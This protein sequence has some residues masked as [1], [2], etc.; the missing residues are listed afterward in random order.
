MGVE[1]IY[2]AL[3]AVS[4]FRNQRVSGEPH[5]ST[6][7]VR[8]NIHSSEAR[9]TCPS[10]NA[11]TASGLLPTFRISKFAAKPAITGSAVFVRLAA[12]QL[13]PTMPSERQIPSC[14][15]FA[16]V[17]TCRLNKGNL[18]TFSKTTALASKTQYSCTAE[19]LHAILQR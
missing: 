9:Q 8:L 11:E 4:A 7:S 6:T 1:P 14:A 17:K 2:T 3:Q 12:I 13:A 18:G 10:F 19:I 16:R 15:V 5:F